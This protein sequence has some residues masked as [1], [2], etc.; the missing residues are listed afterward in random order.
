[1]GIFAN[2][3]HLMPAGI[4]PDAGV[5]D[6]LRLMEA[7]E[8]ERAVCF[9]PFAGQAAG[10]GITDPQRWLAEQIAGR[11]ELLGFATFNPAKPEA[12]AA[13]PE[14]RELGLRGVKLHPAASHFDVAA[15]GAL[16]FY[17][18][19][20]ELG[21]V[22]DF[23]TG[24]HASRL[25]HWEML[26]F[27][28]LAW[29]VPSARII[30]EHMGSRPF[31]SQALAVIGNHL[32]EGGPWVLAGATSCMNPAVP[33]WYLG[34]ERIEEVARLLGQQVLIFGLDFPYNSVEVIRRELELYRAMDLGEGGL[35]GLLGGNLARVL[36]E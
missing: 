12:L 17:A 7:C 8:I 27:D 11:P 3:A 1:M 2:H 33:L 19:A 36:G 31:F 6:L 10:V 25:R 4:R 28:D 32:H 18:A 29:D 20:A 9:A 35:E 14:A 15:P 16:E 21:M 34:A 22:L 13:L 30:L 5:D 24:V 26:K 23:H